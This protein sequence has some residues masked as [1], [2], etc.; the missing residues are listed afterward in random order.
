M[1]KPLG[2]IIGVGQTKFGELFDY[3]LEDLIRQAAIKAVKNAQLR[4]QPA[5]PGYC[6]LNDR[7]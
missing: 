3:S 6:C 2:H 4:L 5:G 7:C 1:N